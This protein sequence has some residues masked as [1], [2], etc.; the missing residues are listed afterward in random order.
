MKQ[1]PDSWAVT[2]IGEITSPS[3]EKFEPL[4]NGDVKY[5]GLEHIEKETGKLLC[6]G[7]SKETRSTK[8]VFRK[9]DLLYGKLRPY[10]N[11][12]YIAEFDGVCSTDILVF[13]KNDFFENKFLKYR[14]LCSDFVRYASRNVS[15]VQHPR[16]NI[17]TISEYNISLPPLNEQTRIVDKIEELFT[18]LDKG[19]ATLKEL[20]QQIKRYRQSV[21]KHAFE[22]KLTEKWR[23]ENKDRLEPASKLIEKIKAERKKALGKKYK[24]P[25]QIDT[26]GLPELPY[27]WEWSNIDTLA[28]SIPYAIKAGPFGS[29]LKKEFYVPQGYKIY[30]QEQVIRNDPY[31]G[32]YYI[33]KE[34]Y[35]TLKSCAIKPGDVLVS[36]VGT[37]GK[38][39]IL[40]ENIEAG[41]INPRLVKFS[42]EKRL[43]NNKLIKIYLESNVVKHYFS[44]SSHGG[45]MDILNLSILRDLPISLPPLLEQEILIDEIE[46]HFSFADKVEQIVDESLNK[47]EALRQSILK[48]AFEGKLVPQDPNDEPASVLLEKIKAERK[49]LEA[50]KKKP[51]K[52]SKT[53]TKV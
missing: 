31:Y 24:E 34:R 27:G 42:L 22:G 10:L 17:N 52:K 29:A 39:L 40:P 48:Q 26:S 16:V 35:E 18:E 41:I 20:K 43:I 25:P 3:S 37:I 1:L 46:K 4:K 12:V 30:G 53:K 47:S 13:P 51:T 38:V 8:S 21:L 45:T 28:E 14:L 2:K 23:E 6:Y 7:S 32:D 50:V 33:N 5:I 36:L 9:E 19:V 49:T 15:G 44:I 11:K